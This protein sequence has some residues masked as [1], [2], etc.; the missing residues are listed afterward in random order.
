MKNPYEFIHNAAHGNEEKGRGAMAALLWI[1]VIMLGGLVAV[2]FPI[3]V[4]GDLVLIA[5]DI[6]VALVCPTNPQKVAVLY[7]GLWG[8]PTLILWQ[9][10]NRANGRATFFGSFFHDVH[11]HG[12]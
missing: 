11:D 12:H 6:V 4:L 1:Q 2:F 3:P 7:L 8:L 10:A 9:I 5:N